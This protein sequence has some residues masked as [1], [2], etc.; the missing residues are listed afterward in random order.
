MHDTDPR[1]RALLA[2]ACAA[3]VAA[4]MGCS[5]GPAVVDA[6]PV[7]MGIMDDTS[8]TLTPDA[9]ADVEADVFAAP[10]Q[11][12]PQIP[13][14][15]GPRIQHVQLATITFADDPHRADDEAFG[16]W[17]VG[18]NWLTTI[19]ADY[20]VSSGTVLANVERTDNAPTTITRD[21]IETLLVNGLLD[22]SIP[23]PT[24]GLASAL[25][26]IYFPRTSMSTYSIG[27][28][29]HG[30][31]THYDGYHFEVHRSGLD[32]AYAVVADCNDG[33]PNVSEL[34][35]IEVVASHEL[36]EAITDPMPFSQPAYW[37]HV[38]DPVP[39]WIYGNEVGDLCEFL[40]A[41][42]TEAGFSVQRIWS[43]S[44]A[45]AGGDPCVPFDPTVPYFGTSVTPNTIQTVMPGAT[46]QFTLQAWSTDVLPPWLLTAFGNGDFRPVAVFNP[47]RVANGATSTLRVTVPAGTAPRSHAQVFV[48]STLPMRDPHGWPAYV[49]APPSVPAPGPGAGPCTLSGIY[50]LPAGPRP[51]YLAFSSDGTWT[52]AADPS[53]LDTR[54]I[55]HGTYT[56]TTTMLTLSD[57]V[58]NSD[59]C[60][61]SQ[62]ATYAWSL[63][64]TC[65][66]LTLHV[67]TDPC[68][69]R[70]SVLDGATL[71]RH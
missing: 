14:Q 56:N 20:G 7:D 49:V 21:G 70:S 25:Y 30:S 12:F 53:V 13:N 60:M 45:A 54:S 66:T 1:S 47:T 33:G 32:F 16:R 62:S 22:G 57:D 6:H 28:T 40:S 17:I 39:W 65:A 69:L 19:G 63:D 37:L 10:H 34:Q 26:M 15:G 31:C 46:A 41:P 48:T 44:A 9:S 55:I 52:L 8:D 38:D 59:A 64:A 50:A 29:V 35:R 27:W 36:A 24:G 71:T 51:L 42:W 61:P 4:A 58:V 11:P 68:T 67:G 2:R 18:S 43:N 3:L 5:N 23:R